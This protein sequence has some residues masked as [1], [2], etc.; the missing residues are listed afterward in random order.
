MCAIGRTLLKAC[1]SS[2][3]GGACPVRTSNRGP[4]SRA[5][6]Y[7]VRCCPSRGKANDRSN[8]LLLLVAQGMMHC[9]LLHLLVHRVCRCHTGVVLLL[10]GGWLLMEHELSRRIR[11]NVIVHVVA[12]VE[13]HVGRHPISRV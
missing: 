5:P 6:H 2:G 12:D 1:D 11:V 10:M 4:S 3:N 13:H 7:L 9:K 8:L